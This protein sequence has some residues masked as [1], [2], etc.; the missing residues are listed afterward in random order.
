MTE[1]RNATRAQQV[2]LYY[3]IKVKNKQLQV[4]DLVLRNIEPRLPASQRGKMTPNWEG[5][6]KVIEKIGYRV[7][8]L[9]RI[10]GT[11]VQ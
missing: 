8:K 4:G 10:E 3:N 7:Y 6:Y 2:S 5:P 11:I 9:A 1:V